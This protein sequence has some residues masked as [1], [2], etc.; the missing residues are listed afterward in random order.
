ML[1][2]MYGGIHVETVDVAVIGGGPGG[3]AAAIAARQ[4]GAE[5]VLIME[6][7]YDLGGIL[8]QCIHDGFGTLV[9]KERVTGPEYA[10]R[11][12]DLVR[13]HGIECRLKT[14]VLEITHDR[15]IVA[16]SPERGITDIAARALVL[17]M[18][19]RERTR[20]QILIPGTRPAG[21]F[22]A[23]SAQR[24]VNI[25][26]LLPGNRAVVLG[27]GDIG[28]IMARRLHLEGVEVEGVYEILP[29]PSG[30]TRNV[31]QCLQ[32]YDIPL[33]LGHTVTEIHGAKRV[34]GVTIAQVDA[35]L[36]PIPGTE[37]LVP[38]DTLILSVGLIP[39]NELSEKAGLDIDTKT[40]GPMVNESMETSVPGIF[41]C[42][43]VVNV[44]DLVDYVTYT[45]ETAG[46]G[47]ARF[48]RGEL[49]P[50]PSW[51]TEAGANVQF[52]VPQAVAPERIDDS[53]NLYFRVR[54]PLIGARV[55]VRAGNS[56]IFSRKER[57]VRP[58][59]MV[60]ARIKP[61][62]LKGVPE[63]EPITVDVIAEPRKEEA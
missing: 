17:A 39:E 26:G 15:R 59:E 50:G 44:Y 53:L 12:R 49:P 33:H 16:V 20:P 10:E 54:E 40:R 29:R 14:M 48:A 18:G 27:S 45:G 1:A 42:G 24:L 36:N 37:R 43:N 7:D 41:A 51:I 11:Y 21:I 32:D 4:A 38:C 19:C 23:G 35:G 55:N 47:A 8:P 63:G 22:T 56:L 58:P 2:V 57:V 3:M 60:V 6:R 9:M 25:E 5:K 31:V 28:L 62:R 34:E 30:L 13:E 46:R 52:V 61:E